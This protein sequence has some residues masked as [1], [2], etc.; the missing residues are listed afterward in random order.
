MPDVSRQRCF[1]HYQREAVARCPECG[2][3]YCREC[4]TE[5]EDRV[6]C[7]ACLR[8]LAARPPRRRRVFA[9]VFRF[10]QCALGVMV[11]W[12]FFYLVGEQLLAI[13]ASFHEGTVWQVPWK[14][15]K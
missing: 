11:L 5:H 12:F 7:A 2:Q 8:K 13:P 6:I 3:F 14:D 15:Q 10:G 1:N 4:I 9:W